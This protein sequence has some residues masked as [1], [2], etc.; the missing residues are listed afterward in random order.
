MTM[1]IRRVY[2]YRYF[3]FQISHRHLELMT[4]NNLLRF[5]PHNGDGVKEISYTKS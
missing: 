2:Q 4:A 5:K 3:L 1:I